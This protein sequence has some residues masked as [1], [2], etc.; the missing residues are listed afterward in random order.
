[1]YHGHIAS[2]NHS[3]SLDEALL[4][5]MPGPYSYTREDVVEIQAHAGAVALK[6]ILDLILEQGAR[7]AEAGEFTRRAYLN[8][9]LD[10]SQAE[11][12]IDVIL[13]KTET[14]LKIASRHLEGEVGCL[15]N[16]IREQLKDVHATLEADIEFPEDVEENGE[17]PEFCRST[18]QKVLGSLGEI[19]EGYRRGHLL[20]EGLR[21]IIV[22]KVN[23]GKSSLLNR[24]LR[25]ERAIVTDVP[26][27]TRD[28]IEE[29]IDI[30]GLPVILI[31][32]AG[33]RDTKDPVEQIGIDRTRD[34]AETAD[35]ILFMLDA[36]RGISYEDHEIYRRIKKKD[37][38]LVVN[39]TDLLIG[40]DRIA[41][42]QD[43]DFF[44]VNYTSVKRDQGIDTLKKSIHRFGTEGWAGHENALVPNL[45]QKKL[46]ER[47]KHAV[48]TAL[49]GLD[50]NVPPELAGMDLKEGID[51]LD[52]ITGV[53]I[54]TDVLDTVFSRFC[55]G[56]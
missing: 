35:L 16:R 30:S 3:E 37:K 21:L 32:T 43:W 12:V 5:F 14:S 25:K 31:D 36:E 26:G 41:V 49:K 45:R 56:K 23:V 34:L 10:L 11:A 33:W 40:T 29:T 52:E 17:R 48:D 22:G 19:L 53:S 7:L 18:L 27:T 20:R 51:A 54:K 6:T 50:E 39:K 8:G 9:R 24:F 13:A 2:P 42:P 4:V 15:V 55:I 38:L 28:H 46:F 44:D 1:M 47:A